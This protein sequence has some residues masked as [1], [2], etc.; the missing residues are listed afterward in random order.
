VKLVEPPSCRSASSVVFIGKNRRGNWV[1]QQQNGLYGGLFVNRAQA[2][3]YALFENGHHPETIVELPGEIEL[4]IGGQLPSCEGSQGQALD[5]MNNGSEHEGRCR[6]TQA[7]GL[8]L[9]R[10][11]PFPQ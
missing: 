8:T 1:A 3:K 9:R 11:R 7:G 10:R 2:V 4:D 5:R 6:E